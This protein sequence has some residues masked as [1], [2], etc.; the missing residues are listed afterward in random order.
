MY[1][2]NARILLLLWIL[3]LVAWVLVH[4]YRR[5][6]ASARA[7]ADPAMVARLMPS[8]AGP[9]A[10]VKGTLLLTGLGLLIAAGARPRFGVY[11]ET[12]RQRGV[13]LFV[14]LDVS[15]SM[16]AEDV[17]PS[18]LERAKSDIRDLL[19]HLAGDRV[20]LI[21]F[22]GKPVVKVPLTNDGGFFR[23][24]LDEVD[25]NSAPRGG[26]LIGDAIRKAMETLPRSR[27]RDQVLVLIT[28]GDDQDSYAEDAA[29]QAAERGMKIFTVGLGD[30][31][32]GARIPVR[33]D[34]GRLSFL[35][36]EGQEKWS[37]LNGKL[38]EQIAMITG[39]A[40]IP[41]GT[42]AYDLG[43]V[44]A[45][46]LAG[47][48]RSEY[49]AEKRKRYREQFQ[50][51]VC[52]GVLLLLMEMGI[53]SYRPNPSVSLSRL[54]LGA[55][56]ER[57]GVRGS[58]EGLAES[59]SPSPP[60]PLPKGEES[61]TVPLSLRERAGVRGACLLL[62]IFL[63]DTSLATAGQR[64]ANEKVRQGIASYRAGNYKDANAAFGEADSAKPDDLRI[65]FNRGVA[66]A[67]EGDADKA[68][69]LLQKAA[70]SPEL[71][72]AVRARYNLG[73]LAAA[74]AKKRFGEHP[75]TAAPDVRKDGLA[76]LATAVGH[77]RDC[78]RMDKDH[79]DSRHNL[80][81][82][83]LWIKS[84]QS[85]WEQNDRKKQREELDLAAFLQML[86]EKQRVL[87]AA[88]RGL[89]DVGPSPKR[90][91]A[92]RAAEEAQRK[93][94]EEIEPLKEKIEATL[95]KAGQQSAGGTAAPAPASD[96]IKKAIT[97]LQTLADAAGRNIESAAARLHAGKPDEAVKPQTETVEMFNQMYRD[98]APY[99]GLVG[100]AVGAQQALTP[101]SSEPEEKDK[102]GAKKNEA[103]KPL[104]PPKPPSPPAPLPKGEGSKSTPAP[105]SKDEGRELGWNQDF[106]T[107]Y[108]EIL[109]PLAKAGLK[110]LESMPATPMAGGSAAPAKPGTASSEDDA[111]K[112]RDGLKKSMEKAVELAPKVEKLSGE[113][114]ELLRD[115][116]Q[117]E[118]L[119]KQQ[120]ALKLLKEIAEPLP[121]QK[122]QKDDK[123]KDDN[124]QDQKQQ[125]DKKDSKPDEKKQ[126]EKKQQQQDP[127]QQKADSAIRQVQDRQQ[128]RQE[129][130]KQMQRYL[131]RSAKVDK[132]W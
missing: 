113:A 73:C 17:A 111:Q 108:A 55:K 122:P 2:E 84:M 100:R 110:Q 95:S 99:P 35:Q 62:A 38:L 119:P 121:K 56:R 85:L 29:K 23:M 18:R 52:L 54:P 7:F 46:H 79:A 53:A 37:K 24:V 103:T 104:G 74:K 124:K 69:E 66:L 90:R 123:K 39:G 101:E 58:G 106:V 118:A 126:D 68:V 28:D 132:D 32:E 96:E 43:Q 78:L 125:Q 42:R 114:A 129:K 13:D 130:E 75:E 12:V 25:V 81:L 94:A 15:R 40:Y 88:C 109:P 83:R 93:L 71:D 26:T 57:V 61:L 65:A 44:Y 49:Q 20:G 45:D 8:L 72:M 4:A 9:R 51:F 115:C 36:Y 19:P 86:E 91:Q 127:A 30:A 98:V 59:T 16:T 131:L 89:A 67:A 10:W 97:Q 21:V 120:E 92:I 64:E 22:A 112:Q 3:P 34:A 82:I 48:T 50:L 47:L 41:A 70:L 5:R 107:R 60:A 33:D 87:R 105:L 117:V 11:T 80:E 116:K 1:W 128:Q 102:T 63:S 77:F 6:L 31:G 76:E 14:L 27:D